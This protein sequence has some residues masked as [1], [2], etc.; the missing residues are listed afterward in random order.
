MNPRSH[1]IWFDQ[2]EADSYWQPLLSNTGK[3]KHVSTSS[4]VTDSSDQIV[5]TAHVQCN[6]VSLCLSCKFFVSSL[7]LKDSFIPYSNL[8]WQFICLGNIIPHSKIFFFFT[9]SL[10]RVALPWTC[11][12]SL[13]FCLC[14]FS[15]V[16]M[17]FS[18]LWRALKLNY[19]WAQ[20]WCHTVL[21]WL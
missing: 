8:V 20:E 2:T 5:L 14:A 1:K 3:Q 13:S 16:F 10:V 17:N 11:G 6:H 18:V 21:T 4:R 15:S 7:K 19:L 9:R 12:F